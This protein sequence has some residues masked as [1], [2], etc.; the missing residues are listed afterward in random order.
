MGTVGEGVKGVVGV[1][2]VGIVGF[3]RVSG[4]QISHVFCKIQLRL[5]LRDGFS[6]KDV[7]VLREMIDVGHQS[8]VGI[9]LGSL[10]ECFFRS[11]GSF[12]RYAVEL[13]S[14]ALQRVEERDEQSKR[15]DSL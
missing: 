2:R 15:L 5:S 11:G 1:E 3:V 9:L 6:G 7:H 4:N 12:S 8:H 14:T 10:L 13:D